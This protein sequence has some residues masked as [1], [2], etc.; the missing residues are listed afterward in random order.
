MTKIKV[1]PFVLIDVKM[2]RDHEFR[3]LSLAAKMLWV[4]IR[5]EYYPKN[6]SHQKGTG[7]LQFY[8]PYSS[9]EDV[10]GLKKD[11]MSRAIKELV[12]AGFIEI[13]E[14][15]GLFEGKNAYHFVGEYAEYKNKKKKRQRKKQKE[16]MAAITKIRPR[17]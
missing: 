1:A 11:A 10:K 6:L 15:G 7:K 16:G 5:A 14:H 3:K 13:T 4:F 2:L 8:L 12:K 9:M 17:K